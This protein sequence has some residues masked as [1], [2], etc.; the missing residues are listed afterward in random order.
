MKNKKEKNETK[1]GN[2]YKD[3]FPR[4]R[5]GKREG[6]AVSAPP[7][8]GPPKI[9]GTWLASSAEMPRS[10]CPQAPERW[11]PEDSSANMM[12][13]AAR[14]TQE[15]VGDGEATSSLTTFC[16]SASHNAPLVLLLELVLELTRSRKCQRTS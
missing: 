3:D 1:V 9:G 8:S 12:G 10:T 11:S 4:Y 5:S 7:S 13:V 16:S 2:T 14:A 6:R 15:D